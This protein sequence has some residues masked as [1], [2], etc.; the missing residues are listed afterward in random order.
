LKKGFE[1]YGNQEWLIDIIN[2]K[3]A[4]ISS[5]LFAIIVSVVYL[6]VLESCAKFILISGIFAFVISMAGLSGILLYS[7]YEKLQDT[8]PVT[9]SSAIYIGLGFFSGIISVLMTLLVCCLWSRIILAA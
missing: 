8:D 2:A 6:Y 1:K 7:E 9:G 3:W 4:I 5:F